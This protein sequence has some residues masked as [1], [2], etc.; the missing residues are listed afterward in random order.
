[1]NVNSWSMRS[2]EYWYM[3]LFTS[4]LSLITNVRSTKLLDVPWMSKPDS[5]RR[6][7][8]ATVLRSMV[9]ST[10]PPA[11]IFSLARLLPSKS[12]KKR[13]RKFLLDKITASIKSNCTTKR[14]VFFHSEE[15]E[16][17]SAWPAGKK[18]TVTRSRRPL[19]ICHLNSITPV[20]RLPFL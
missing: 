4:M 1:M 13:K 19:R 20:T 17:R 9:Y 15:K 2:V 10:K 3:T 14:P 7:Q 5:A 11:H 18:R 12:G 6:K 8:N 16:T